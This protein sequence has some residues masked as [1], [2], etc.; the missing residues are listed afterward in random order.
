MDKEPE[1]RTINRRHFLKGTLAVSGLVLLGACTTL[2]AETSMK[3]IEF[4]SSPS[5]EQNFSKMPNGPLDKNVWR[6]DLDPTIP[7]YNQESQGYTDSER[8]VRIENGNLVIEAHREPYAYPTGEKFEF[9]SGRIDTRDSFDFEYGKFEVTM[10]VP[11]GAGTWPAFW[12]LSSTEPYTKALHPSDSDWAQPRFYKHDGELDA[13]EMYGNN[14]GVAEGTLHTFDKDHTFETKMKDASTTFHTYG[15]EVT[16]E[17]VNW[18]IDGKVFGT[19]NKPS[20][21]PNKW[22][23][24]NGN[25]FYLIL[26]LAMGG[27]AGA[28]DTN[29]DSWSMQIQNVQ[30]FEYK[31]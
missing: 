11:E 22:P 16:P 1:L 31:K 30:F 29:T 21:D 4:E 26:N 14:P 17:K 24:G 15:V 7:T 8:N 13:L 23:F 27:L 19:Y 3:K 9:T 28:I 18:T 20:D 6:F 25:R 5:W 12:F 2:I 10:K